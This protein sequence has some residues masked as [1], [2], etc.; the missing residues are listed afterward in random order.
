MGKPKEMLS[1]DAQ[2]FM[3]EPVP[4]HLRVRLVKVDRSA[5]VNSKR[6]FVKGK[7][8]K[9]VTLAPFEAWDQDDGVV[10]DRDAEKH[11]QER[12][13]KR[14]T[15][16][17]EAKAAGSTI[18]AD[19][20][21]RLVDSLENLHSKRLLDKKNAAINDML[22]M[23]GKRYR[24]H[25]HDAGLHG[26]AAMDMM[27]DVVDGG[28]SDG[29]VA[30]EHIAYSRE[31]IRMANA[32]VGPRC[33]A[34]FLG[35]VLHEKSAAQLRHLVAETKDRNAADALVLDRLR[36]GLHRCSALWKM[37]PND[38]ASMRSWSAS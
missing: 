17:R 4:A 7:K 12:E 37:Q 35:V 19:R 32:A 2:E 10:K 21:Q 26:V 9:N 25:F 5:D 16:E 15:K 29:D 23:A 20:V 6:P 14:A 31:Q 28:R 8:P 24:Q 38:R 22:M 36:E 33:A 13:A 30:A 1:P 18:G 34:C 3:A 11:A 27:R